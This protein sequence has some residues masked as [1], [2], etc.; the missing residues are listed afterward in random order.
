MTSGGVPQD[1]ITI[2]LPAETAT[3][4]L[5]EDIAARLKPGD[6]VAL[7][8]DLGAGKTT[9]ARALIRAVADAPDLEVPSPTFTLVQ[10][11]ATPRLTVAH[12]DLYR[13][14]GDELEE[15]GFADAAIDGAVLV[16]WPDR[17]GDRLPRERLDVSLAIAGAGRVAT[18]T[19]SGAVWSRFQRSHAARALLDD[20]GWAGATRRHLQGDAS[21]RTYERIARGHSTA[22]LMDWPSRGQLTEGDPRAAYRAQDARVFAAVAA[23]LDDAG[24][25]VPR[26]LKRDG[27]LVL[28]EDFGSCGVVAGDAPI[29]ERYR[30]AIE[31]LAALHAEP[32]LRDIPG[33]RLPRLTGDVLLTEVAILADHYVPYLHGGPLQPD[34]RA[35]LME[36]W[37]D[38]D[39]WLQS[40]EQSWVLFDVQ[41]PNLFWLPERQGIRRIG[42]IDFQDMF[43][44]PAAYDVASLC[45]DARVTVSPELEDALLAQYVACRGPAF[46]ADSFRAAYAVTGALRIAKILGAFARAATN[47]N[48]RYI[49]HLPRLRAYL[50]RDLRAPVLSPFAVWYERHLSPP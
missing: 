31:A 8:G 5:A 47:G 2:D 40:T 38:L 18:I 41:S 4:A 25:S 50:S 46:D 6:V 11:Y 37:R 13:L 15:I 39:L 20:A 12:F 35:E 48:D 30:I 16:E 24:L 22:V 33:H 44:G 49:K 43:V 19:G 10:T 14:S 26:I 34:A 3:V 9:L 32:R 23:A 28:M 45:Q 27:G 1:H 42:F 7:W 29:A 17:A 36:I 21:T